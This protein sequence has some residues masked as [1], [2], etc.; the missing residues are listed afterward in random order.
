MT[1]SVQ[2]I[3]MIAMVLSGFYLGIIHDTFRRLAI[4]WRNRVLLS[5]FLEICFWL[6]QTGIIFY[7][8]FRANGGE[9]RLYIFLACFLGF[10]AYQALAADVYKRVLEY[11]IQWFAAV[12]RFFK[13]TVQV[14]LFTP[15]KWMVLFLAAVLLWLAKLLGI[16]LLSLWKVAITPIYWLLRLFLF[17]LPSSWQ[18][19]L[20]KLAGVYSTIKNI[21]KKCREYIMSKRR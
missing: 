11:L 2:F 14:L 1:L 15:V 7:I 3:T 17:L 5:Y 18:K 12:W 20:H 16:I 10:A 19:N 9:L 13:R 4:Y 8:L 21:Y 6:A